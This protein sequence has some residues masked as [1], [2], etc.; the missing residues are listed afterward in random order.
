MFVL[1]LVLTLVD[2]ISSVTLREELVYPELL[3]QRSDDGRLLLRI[4]RDMTLRLERS[5]VLAND[6]FFSTNAA[7]KYENT[8]WN[9]SRIQENLYHDSKH[10]SSVMLYQDDHT[11]RVEGI[12]SPTLRIKPIL[13][14]ERSRDPR[15]LHKVYEIEDPKREFGKYEQAPRRPPTTRVE[16]LPE[17]YVAE[18]H[19]VSCSV[20]EKNFE[21]NEELI[22]Y[23]AILMNA[24]NIWYEGMENPRIKVKVVGITRNKDGEFE[25]IEDGFLIAERTINSFAEYAQTQL[26]G[27]PDAVYLMTGQDL[28]SVS[29]SGTIDNGV[30]G[31]AYVAMLCGP[32]NVAIGEDPAGSFKGVYPAA[33]E[34]AH[35]L[36]SV[37]DGY[38]GVDHIPDH[39]GAKDCPWEEGYL[40]SYQDGGTKKFHLS[41]CSEAQIRAT[42]KSLPQTCLDEISEEDYMANHRKLPGQL[43]SPED[44][45]NILMKNQGRGVPL[46]K[47]DM[48]KEC[49]FQ[50]CLRTYYGAGKCQTEYVLEGMACD[51]GKTCR[52]GV[53]DNFKWEE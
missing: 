15:I 19:V 24:V 6:L 34:L 7:G 44:Y 16:Q 30:A 36:G 13:L 11:L 10:Q 3:Q 20:H 2:F 37:H 52:K 53:C 33:H 28:A 39:P 4:N 48:L 41:P 22:A 38:A 25:V 35:T 26:P 18:V 42:L 29:F 21:T 45:C 27:K 47:P 46:L 40:M 32:R 51:E 12:L 43:I 49:R 17:E 31:L 8:L 5:L 23:I 50:C 1:T 9:G 14:G